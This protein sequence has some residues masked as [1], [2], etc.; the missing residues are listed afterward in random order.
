MSDS[1]IRCIGGPLDGKLV[2]DTGGS[3]RHF[4]RIKPDLGETIAF[5][6]PSVAQTK[7]HTHRLVRFANA[8]SAQRA[9]RYVHES[10]DNEEA[11]KRVRRE[12][13]FE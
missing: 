8:Q 9:E 7:L 12:W 5:G 1:P 2:E 3:Y 13:G 6:S 11:F 10:I 4:E